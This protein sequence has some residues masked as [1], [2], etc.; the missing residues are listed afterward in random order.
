VHFS[1]LA[2]ELAGV[3]NPLYVQHDSMRAEGATIIDLVKGNV[4]E[5]GIVFPPETLREILA[6]AAEQARIYRPDSLG[7]PAARA[8]IAGYYAGLHIPA[9][10]IVVTPGTSISYWYCF[11]LLSEP[12]DEILCPQ[13]SYPLFEYIAR[14]SGV[15]M[16]HY[17]L[18][19]A[20]DWAIDLDYLESQ[21]TTRTRAIVVISPHNPTG[22]LA[23]DGQLEGLAEIAARHE[24]PIISDEVF[25]EFLFEREALPRAAATKAPLVFTLNGFSKMFAM[26]G[27]KLG[28]MAVSGEAALVRKATATLEMISDTFLPVN[29]IIQFAV[30]AIFTRGQPF[31]RDYKA[32]VSRC[33]DQAIAN[34]ADVDFVRPAAG[35]YV[36]LPTFDEED[37]AARGLL[38]D[39]GIL[40]HPGYY[41]DIKPNHL[42]MTFIHNPRLLAKTFRRISSAVRLHSGA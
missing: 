35:F 38:Q 29:E 10:Q 7:Q 21:I 24:L 42:V 3:K 18:V 5:H 17:R 31:L 6:E 4:N 9:G 27:I 19:E 32:W 26:P 39:H 1:E 40:T 36:T 37:E 15:R 41:Y 22:M 28:W 13:P 16:T 25:S 14:I 8:A 11:K 34:L 33:H 12:G 23:D 2:D 30:P 20:R